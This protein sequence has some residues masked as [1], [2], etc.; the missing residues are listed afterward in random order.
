MRFFGDEVIQKA[1]YNKLLNSKG[2]QTL[3][4]DSSFGI[5]VLNATSGEEFDPQRLKL[6]LMIAKR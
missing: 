1:C 3:L 5:M 4:F 2:V 6:K